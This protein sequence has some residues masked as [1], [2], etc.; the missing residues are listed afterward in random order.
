MI[1]AP[2]INEKQTLY[3]VKN[4]FEPN[5][6]IDLLYD[7]SVAKSVFKKSICKSKIKR[8]FNKLEK[9]SPDF[10]M[11]WNIA[12]FVKRAEEIYYYDNNI[13]KQSD[14]LA[15]YSSR[16]YSATD[17][18]FKI[19][20]KNNILIVKLFSNTTRVVID[21]E[22]LSGSKIKSHFVFEYEQWKSN[23]NKYD[24]M[25]LE[26]IIK[27]IVSHTKELFNYCMYGK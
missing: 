16:N 1:L 19:T 17:N 26:E 14:T 21:D 27:L 15:L 18:G 20:T 12:S 8:F 4:D 25:I 2:R 13:D 23:H 9:S 10:T 7:L 22:H 6:F 3:T 24:E 5:I 11:L